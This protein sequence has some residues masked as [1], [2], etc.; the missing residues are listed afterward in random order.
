MVARNVILYF[1]VRT[2]CLGRRGTGMRFILYLRLFC[3][4][5]FKKTIVFSYCNYNYQLSNLINYAV[6]SIFDSFAGIVTLAQRFVIIF[7]L[8]QL[9]HLL[10]LFPVRNNKNNHYK[11]LGI[12]RAYMPD[13]QIWG[14]WVGWVW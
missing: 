8:S 11:I 5:F 6:R 4:I 10:S 9:T 2:M 7:S 12:I 13:T 14:Y 3:I 1:Y